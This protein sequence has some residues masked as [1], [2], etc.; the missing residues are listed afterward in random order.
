[1][2]VPSSATLNL[3]RQLGFLDFNNFL[4]C[5]S[6]SGENVK[7]KKDFVVK[8]VTKNQPFLVAHLS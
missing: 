4:S 2:E 8:N 5:K 1:M 7:D 3:E 6:L